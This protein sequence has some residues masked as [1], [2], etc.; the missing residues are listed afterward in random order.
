M[1]VR[2]FDLTEPQRTELTVVETALRRQDLRRIKHRWEA[3]GFVAL[4]VP[5][6]AVLVIVGVT[7]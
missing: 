3:V 1:A 5:F 6:I 4:V 2:V 7:H